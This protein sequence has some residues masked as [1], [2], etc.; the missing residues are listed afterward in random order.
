MPAYFHWFSLISLLSFSTYS[1]YFIFEALSR[2]SAPLPA[3]RLAAADCRWC[4]YF[5][6]YCFHRL[7]FGFA[8]T[9]ADAIQS[10]A[11]W[12]FFAIFYWGRL[13]AVSI[14]PLS[15]DIFIS[16]QTFLRHCFDCLPYAPHIFAIFAAAIRLSCALFR[17]AFFSMPPLFY[18]F[19]YFAFF[20][21]ALFAAISLLPLFLHFRHFRY[22]AWYIIDYIDDTPIFH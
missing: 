12:H 16:A 10:S 22:Y 5:H 3:A 14:L 21:S 7:A 2:L 4:H 18:F 1:I 8:I 11:W 6:W 20:A 19:D 17:Q 13:A 15:F 9:L